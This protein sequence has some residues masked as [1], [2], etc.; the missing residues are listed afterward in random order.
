MRRGLAIALV[1]LAGAAPAYL[2]C[3]EVALARA[4]LTPLEEGLDARGLAPARAL[5]SSLGDL[6]A[7]DAL[8][9]VVLL[10]PPPLPDA[11]RAALR[12]HVEAGGE[13]WIVSR[14][15]S[16]VALDGDDALRA[17]AYPGFL[18]AGNGSSPRVQVADQGVAEMRGLF[19]LDLGA[20]WEPLLVTDRQAFRDT[21]GNGR[22]D[23]GEP[24]GPFVAAARA[25][26]GDGR[27]VVIGA[28]DADAI[29]P[30]V[31]SAL[32]RDARAGTALLVD[33]TAPAWA[34]PGL[35]VLA[36]TGL[37]AGSLLAAA[38]VVA[39]AL[40][41][42]LLLASR[43]DDARA[44]RAGDDVSR[45]TSAFAARLRARGLAED[46]KLLQSLEGDTAP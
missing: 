6:R 40:G 30:E 41:L 2:T 20:A 28:D 38:F 7:S 11:E 36:V 37:P 26:L 16:L 45:L 12:R 24:G 22:L 27:I 13:L 29:P 23:G 8:S 3:V 17:Q 14:D 10:G 21:N 31:A 34:A 18:Y 44:E 15:A 5:G 4:P 19:A 39:A 43:R 33:H 42:L 32:A 1:V 25:K 46:R 35:R 9:L